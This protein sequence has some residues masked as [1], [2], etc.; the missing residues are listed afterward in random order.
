MPRHSGSTDFDNINNKHHHSGSV[1]RGNNTTNYNNG[2][3][4]S[5]PDEI[6]MSSG[7]S[8]SVRY[9]GCVEVK[10]SMKT[11]DFSTR[12]QVARECINRVCETA[13]LKIQKKRRLDKDFAIHIRAS[14]YGECR[15]KCY[16]KCF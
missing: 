5:Y 4:C 2:G 6:I 12:S 3:G 15:H 10:T 9:I 8:F 16:Y 11:L 7:V 13:G 14:L 1:L